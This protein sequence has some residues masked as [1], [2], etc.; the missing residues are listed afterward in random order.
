MAYNR[1]RDA[2]GRGVGKTDVEWV[3]DET[4]WTGAKKSSKNNKN[5]NKEPR[6]KRDAI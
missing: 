1:C 4:K 2:A 6:G 5:K 3:M